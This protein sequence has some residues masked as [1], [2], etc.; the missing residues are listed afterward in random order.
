MPPRQADGD[1]EED[2]VSDHW[3]H[4]DSLKRK[5]IINQHSIRRALVI[6]KGRN[7][8][9]AVF[10]MQSKSYGNSFVPR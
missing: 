10:F 9:E 1:G 4:L 7:I 8:M 5:K 3:S 6:R 2:G